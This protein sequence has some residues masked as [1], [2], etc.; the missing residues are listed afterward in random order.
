MIKNSFFINAS[1]EERAETPDELAARFLRVIDSLKQVNPVFSLWTCGANGPRKFEAV[2]DRYASEIAAGVTTDDWGEPMPFDGY[3]FGAF[4]RETP[5]DRLF[6]INIKAGSTVDRPFTNHMT[7]SG[8]SA[9]VPN[10]NFTSYHLFRAVLGIIVD[11]WEPARAAAY[12]YALVE[13]NGDSYFRDP[14][15]QYLCPWLARLI[16]PPSSAHVEH[17]P[18]GGLVMSA[19]TETFD[20]A[21]PVHLAVARDIGAAMAPLNEL[22]WPSSARTAD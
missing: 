7:F 1:W 18:D 10:T 2:R 19:T 8:D 14:W 6:A 13:I 21:N 22:P 12:S 4:T 11:I 20:V 5:P 3:W 17:L 15:I 16:T 9:A